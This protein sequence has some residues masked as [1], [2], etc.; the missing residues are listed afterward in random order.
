MGCYVKDLEVEYVNKLKVK[1][2]KKVEIDKGP[3]IEVKNLILTENCFIK[4]EGM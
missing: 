1:E 3:K 2:R 4:P